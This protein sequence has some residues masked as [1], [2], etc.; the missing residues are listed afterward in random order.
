M[1]Q[2]IAAPPPIRRP[3]YREGQLLQV[4]E[5]QAEQQ[6]RTDALA[7]HEQKVHAPGIAFGLEV[8]I[9][10]LLAGIQIQPG[11]AV[12][13]AGRYLVLE[14]PLTASLTDGEDVTVSIV[15]RGGTSQIE[16]SDT[17][18]PTPADRTADAWPV[19]LC[20]AELTG[21]T[22]I[23]HTDVREDLQLGAAALIDPVGGSRVVLGGQSGHRTQVLGVQLSDDKGGLVDVSTVNADGTGRVGIDISVAGH[24][25]AGGRVRLPTPAPAPQAAV[26]WSLYRT[27]LTRPDNTVAEQVRLEVGEVKG[28][29]NPQAVELLVATSRTGAARDLL[30][31]D[32]GT[33]VTVG[34]SLTVEGFTTVTGFPG[35]LPAGTTLASLAAQ[36]AQ[37]LAVAQVLLS[38]L[39]NSDLRAALHAGPA[40]YGST[41]VTYTLRLTSS[42][43][44]AVTAVAAYE[45]VV[46][47]SANTLISGQFIAQ[48]INLPAASTYDRSRRV[49]LGPHPTTASIAI[50]AI[51]VGQDGQPR[52]GTLQ[53]QAST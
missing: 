27:T 39:T 12:D 44:T 13:G 11:L 7:R 18:P 50:M 37:L 29:V 51:G 26:P 10:A 46:N 41:A 40:R 17:P 42:A 21:G 33:T 45:T 47:L 30:R 43:T 22:V 24:V 2:S 35:P 49:T 53:F 38:Q 4:E 32:A 6:S 14:H 52:I 28:G 36:E 25:Q 5:L 31:V 48:G 15:W 1:P 8:T 9:A 16:L 34:G 19:I 23:V 20:R 3:T